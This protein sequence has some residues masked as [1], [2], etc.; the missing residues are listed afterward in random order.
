MISEASKKANLAYKKKHR[1]YNLRLTPEQYEVVL[2]AARTHGQT[3]QQFILETVLRR[4]ETE[5]QA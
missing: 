3:V 5:K 4:I 1:Y 2:T